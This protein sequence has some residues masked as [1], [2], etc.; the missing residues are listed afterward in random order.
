MQSID[1]IADL[2]NEHATGE[3]LESFLWVLMM[4]PDFNIQRTLLVMCERANANESG[5][6]SL[7]F[8]WLGDV[9]KPGLM[10]S[11]VYYMLHFIMC[12]VSTRVFLIRLQ[13]IVEYINP[14]IFVIRRREHLPSRVCEAIF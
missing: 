8:Y 2:Y 11:C 6:R 13:V 3:I 14:G 10:I 9:K 5:K 1:L 12:S 7:S 4:F